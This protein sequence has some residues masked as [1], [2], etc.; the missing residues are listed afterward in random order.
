MHDQLRLA[1]PLTSLL[2]SPVFAVAQSVDLDAMQD[3][4]TQRSQT[5][6]ASTLVLCS[7]FPNITPESLHLFASEVFPESPTPILLM[8][9][10]HHQSKILRQ[11][12]STSGFQKKLA[13][14]LRLVI[15]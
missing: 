3:Y 14:I 9:P 1:L 4:L 6:D 10:L 8:E 13:A 15:A 2:F 5:I 11:F 7:E 12:T